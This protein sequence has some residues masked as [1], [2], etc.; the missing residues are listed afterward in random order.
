MWRELGDKAQLVRALNTLAAVRSERGDVA[1]SMTFN[2]EVLQLN[3]ELN[4]QWGVAQALSDV[5]WSAVFVGDYARGTPLLEESLALQRTLQDTFGIAWSALAL[6]V[7][8]FLQNEN[9]PAAALMAESLRLFGAMHNQWYIAGC[10][11]VIAGIAG[12]QGNFQRAAQLLGAHDRLVDVMGAKIPVFWERS[13]RQ[14]LLAQVNAA[15]DEA[16]FKAEW[17]KGHVLTLEQSI[18]L[19]LLEV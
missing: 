12:A 14:P 1:G 13:I 18:E 9:D 3:R 19:A 7:A 5:G 11:E 16:T 8:R 4:D 15:M 10:L 6:G 17:D 2:E